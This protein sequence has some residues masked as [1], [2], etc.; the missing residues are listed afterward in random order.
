MDG[1]LAL[2][3]ILILREKEKKEAQKAFSHAHAFFEK[4]ATHL[5]TLLRTKEEAEESYERFIQTTTP[6]DRIKEQ[7]IYIEKLNK[8]ILTLQSEVQAA[9]DEMNQRQSKLTNA[10]TEVKKFEKL[11]DT[12]KKKYVET[13]RKEEDETM[14]ELSIKR[15]SHQ[16][17]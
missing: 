7:V 2:S 12:R 15:F 9:R 17:N 4:T 16:K 13:I 11:I 8:H 14:D 6:L 1:V 3:K 5:Y 10:H